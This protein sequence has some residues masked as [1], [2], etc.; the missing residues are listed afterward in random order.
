MKREQIDL[1][2]SY[3]DVIDLARNEIQNQKHSGHLR[4]S[5]IRLI[6]AVAYCCSMGVKGDIVEF[7]CWTGNS[8]V[9]LAEV[10]R[11]FNEKNLRLENKLNYEKR[12]YF[13]DSF[14]GLPEISTEKD[15]DNLHV[16]S[17]IW[18]K[19]A[20]TWHSA[21]TLDNLIGQILASDKYKIIKGY[22]SDTVR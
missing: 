17:G 14:S 18:R 3:D 2:A 16:E 8:S 11:L 5:Y 10:V 22:F 7:G 19:G 12:L 6:E 4:D 21:E 15:K 9:V 1:I 13:C 20:M